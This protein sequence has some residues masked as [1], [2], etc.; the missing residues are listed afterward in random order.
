MW[1][2]P[3]VPGFRPVHP[4]LGTFLPRASART[5]FNTRVVGLFRRP[6]PPRV[7]TRGETTSAAARDTRRWCRSGC[8]R[9]C[10]TDGLCTNCPAKRGGIRPTGPVLTLIGRRGTD[11]PGDARPERADGRG[12]AVSTGRA[13]RGF[14]AGFPAV[15]IFHQIAP[16]LLHFA[17]V[18]PA[19]SWNLTPVPP[20]S[21]PA[22]L[23]AAFWGGVWGIA[24]ARLEPRS[25][26]RRRPLAPRP[27]VR[28][29]GAHA[30]RLARRQAAQGTAGRGRPRLAGVTVGPIVNGAWGLGTVLLLRLLAGRAEGYLG[31]SRP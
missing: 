3:A 14:V 6:A 19:T 8:E 18:A 16:L 31:G 29:R 9:A 22:V 20:L 24:P 23:S 17:G 25:G 11:R 15:L 5:G 13:V 7:R 10:L 26:E 30:G 4:G 2:P 28:R 27:P 21:V 12:W 1:P